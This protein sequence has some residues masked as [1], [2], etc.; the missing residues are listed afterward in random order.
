MYG[1][2]RGG[3]GDERRRSLDVKFAQEHV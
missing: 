1:K 3:A 2:V